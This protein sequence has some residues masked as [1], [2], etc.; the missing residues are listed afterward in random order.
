MSVHYTPTRRAT[1]ADVLA[2]LLFLACS[3][4]LFRESVTANEVYSEDDTVTYYLPLAQRIDAMLDEGR[5]PL[6]TPYVFGGHPLFAD[7]ESAV[8]YPPNFLAW[9]LLSPEAAVAATRILRFWLASTFA[10]AF[11]RS[12]GLSRP[13][14][15]LAGLVFGFGSFMVGQIHH[16]NL[17]DAAAWLPAVLW[18]TERAL[19]SEGMARRRW[20]LLG[21]LALGLQL[22][23]IHVNPVLMTLMLLGA[24]LVARLAFLSPRPAGAE[25]LRGALGVGAGGLAAIGLGGVGMA[26]MQLLPLYQ[27]STFSFRGHA[28]DWSFANAFNFPPAN[29]LTLLLPYFFREPA[30]GIYWSPWFRWNTTLYVGIVPLFFAL[31]AVRT[32]RRGWAAFF[33]AIVVVGLWLALGASAPLNLFDVVRSLPILSSTR[34]PSRF[35]FFVVFGL[36]VLA[37]LGL[38]ALVGLL[39]RGAGRRMACLLAAAAL[40][41]VALVAAAHRWVPGQRPL[42]EQ[43]LLQPYARQAGGN[44]TLTHVGDTFQALLASLDPATGWTARTLVALCAT[45]LLVVGLALLPRA[46]AALQVALLL[47]AAADLVLFGRDFH[48]RLP[49]AGVLAGGPAVDFLAAHNGLHRVAT[50]FDVWETAPNRLVPNRIADANGYSSLLPDRHRAYMAAAMRLDN[51]LLDLMGVRYLVQ[52]RANVPARLQSER[53]VFQDSEVAIFERPTALPRALVVGMASYATDPTAALDAMTR[54]GFDPTRLAVVEDR[55]ALGALDQSAD[56]LEPPGRAEVASYSAERV[57]VRASA[58][59]P[60]LLVLADT[61]Y[62]GWRAFVDGREAPI[63]RADYLFRGVPLPPGDHTIRFVFQPSIVEVGAGVSLGTL[64]LVLAGLGSTFAWVRRLSWR[65]VGVE[66]ESK[67]IQPAG[68]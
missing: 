55:A 61:Y 24:Y 16:K 5:L 38:D 1:W 68:A 65:A 51:R 37:G 7:S 30:S 26:A 63:Y 22:T 29:V 56:P 27:L 59:R 25:T 9:L 66:P 20:W 47:V 28:V 40:L 15:A 43:Y 21:A 49:F 52:R 57:V 53:P 64:A 42:V 4:A 19:R 39:A 6:W 18:C 13:G 50:S 35:L 2:I 12:A 34:V 11:A 60:S 36:A 62:P 17:A 3:L 67:G 54:P 32:P 45:A 48:P 41:P 8:L 58:V 44:I 10:Y 31:A 46:R 33:G 14:S 23:T